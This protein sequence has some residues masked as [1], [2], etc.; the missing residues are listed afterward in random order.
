MQLTAQ[1]GTCK[2]K[3]RRSG[4]PHFQRYRPHIQT[5]IATTSSHPP[6]MDDAYRFAC[7]LLAARQVDREAAEMIC[8]QAKDGRIS[9]EQAVEAWLGLAF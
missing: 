4:L 3:P 6:H 7:A 9:H 1:A 8:Q 5:D 2:A